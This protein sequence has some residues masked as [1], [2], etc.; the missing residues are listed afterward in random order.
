MS[1]W[2]SPL[3]WWSEYLRGVA[4][5]WR[6]RTAPSESLRSHGPTPRI[7]TPLLSLCVE[8]PRMPRV[9][10]QKFAED[11]RKLYLVSGS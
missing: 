11:E 2:L 10:S 6:V 3:Y 9:E 8:K 1:L 4:T 5:A 7:R